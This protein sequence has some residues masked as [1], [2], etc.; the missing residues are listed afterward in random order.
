MA[1]RRPVSAVLDAFDAVLDEW[2]VATWFALPNARLG[3]D[4]PVD[5]LERNP[6]AVLQ[7]ARADRSVARV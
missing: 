6:N 2:G 5:V 1:V 7:A 3:D 4:A